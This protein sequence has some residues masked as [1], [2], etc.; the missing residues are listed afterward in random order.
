MNKLSP[1]QQRIVEHEGSC[2]VIGA[3]GT[4]KTDVLVE[5]IA[6]LISK[7]VAPEDIYVVAFTYYSWQVLT[8]QLRKRL[9]DLVDKMHI[10]TLRIFAQ[11]QIEKDEG[12]E[13]KFSTDKQSRRYIRQAMGEVGFK[14]SAV[15]AEHIIRYFKSLARKPQETA[16]H[17]DLLCAY[18]RLCDLDRY[19]VLRKHIIGIR[20]GDYKRVPMKYIFVDN[21]QDITRIQFL[22]LLDHIKA[23]TQASV[24]GDDDLCAFKRDGAIAAQAFNDLKDIDYIKP[25]VLEHSYRMSTPLAASLQGLITGLE[26]HI[27]KNVQCDASKSIDVKFEEFSSSDEELMVLVQ[28]L[29]AIDPQK[30]IGVITRTDWD[31]LRVQKSLEKQGVAHS[32][33]AH[34]IWEIPGAIMVLDLLCLLLNQSNDIHLRNVLIGYGL[35]QSLID[36]LFKAG[37]HGNDWLPNG[38][39]LPKDISLPQGAVAEYTAIQ[40]QL[41]GYYTLLRNG[42]ASPQDIFKAAALDMIANMNKEDRL[43]ALVAVDTLVN[44]KGSLREV[45]PQIREGKE[46]NV[47][48]NVIVGPVRDMRNLQFDY[49]FLPLA[50]KDTYPYKGYTVLPVDEVHDKKL[51]YMAITRADSQ[52]CISWNGVPSSYVSNM[53]KSY[54]PV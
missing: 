6:H 41:V 37:L 23:G 20:Q 34:K 40:R 14:G 38:A 46:P 11:N 21:F 15:E 24:F 7:G 10:G 4:G 42:S 22:W 49:V 12:T 33:F 3:P 50:G 31:A 32:S 25:F 35:N 44:L 2:S 26:G 52:V 54:K 53:K 16:P 30:R 39:R 48:D 8:S 27:P 1:A 36:S 28:K 13:F 9:G 43:N 51:F 18:K 45:L 17:F 19:D 29:K 5:R 47:H